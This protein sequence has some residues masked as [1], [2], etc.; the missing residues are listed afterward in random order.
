VCQPLTG[1][2]A[3]ADAGPLPVRPS[4]LIVGT[5]TR[6]DV[7]W[8]DGQTTRRILAKAGGLL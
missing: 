2:A 5:R 6:V 1:G 8:Q 7:H 3:A 4:C